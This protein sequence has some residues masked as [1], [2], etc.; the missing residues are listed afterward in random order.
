MIFLIHSI[1]NL[2]FITK[3]DNL[4]YDLS[5]SN[6]LPLLKVLFIRDQVKLI[7]DLNK[8][9]DI[10]YTFYRLSSFYHETRQLGL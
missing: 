7:R 6:S 9:D 3:Q 10:P 1:D 8:F 5:I 4:V 2:T